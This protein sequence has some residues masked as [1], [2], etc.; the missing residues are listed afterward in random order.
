MWA[1]VVRYAEAGDPKRPGKR[2]NAPEGSELGSVA[3]CINATGPGSTTVGLGIDVAS[4][5]DARERGVA[6]ANAWAA[7]WGIR[8]EPVS[9]EVRG[10][11]G[12]T[13]PVVPSHE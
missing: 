10:P 2:F 7:D 5:D 11:R 9:V 8:P 6:E 4:E 1:V 13:A 12:S 3:I